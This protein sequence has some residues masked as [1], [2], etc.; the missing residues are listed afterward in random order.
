M[1]SGMENVPKSRNHNVREYFFLFLFFLG[2]FGKKRGSLGRSGNK[3]APS[4][5]GQFGFMSLSVALLKATHLLSAFSLEA[6][7]GKS[8]CP[9]DPVFCSLRSKRKLSSSPL[10]PPPVGDKVRGFERI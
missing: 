6:F 8:L 5:T 3:G 7:R 1:V 9:L 2:S 10:I 4:V